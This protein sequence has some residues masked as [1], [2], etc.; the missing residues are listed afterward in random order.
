MFKSVKKS[1]IGGCVWPG[2]LTPATGELVYQSILLLCNE[3][4]K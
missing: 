1:F 4:G 2:V 3:R